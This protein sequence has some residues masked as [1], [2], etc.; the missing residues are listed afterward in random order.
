MFA[1]GVILA[2][3]CFFLVLY[4]WSE[5]MIEGSEA[6]ILATVYC[7]LAFGIFVSEGWMWLLAFI[8]FVGAI[9]YTLYSFKLGGMRAIYRNQCKTYMLTIQADPSNRAAREYLAQTLY[10]MGELERSVEEM[11]FA[12][13]MGGDMEAQYRLNQWERELHERDSLNPICR[14]CRTENQQDA[15]IC[16]KCGADLPYRS[17]LNHW[18]A[19]GR[20]ASSRYYLILTAGAT[21]VIV[22]LIMS[23][24]FSLPLW[25]ALFPVA[26]V[27]M[28]LVGWS[29][30]SSAR[31]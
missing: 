30:I 3:I 29:L 31:S 12:V 13:K 16:I 2:G 21:L 10:N 26:L 19:G 27:V 14:W 6:F 1:F 28:A 15:R 18:I 4:W 5:G 24:Y 8:T 25:F 22:S 23:R 17:P 20:T 9:A 7:G 11:A